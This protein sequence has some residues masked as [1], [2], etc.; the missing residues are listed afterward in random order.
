MT[1]RSYILLKRLRVVISIFMMILLTAYL[2]HSFNAGAPQSHN[3][4]AT[5]QFLPDLLKLLAMGIIIL[6]TIGLV[7]I[8]ILTLLF[9]RV[10]CSMI[11][12]LGI[13]QDIIS[14]FKRRVTPR[15]MHGYSSLPKL[16]KLR[17]SVLVLCVVAFSFG[18]I[19][20]VMLLEPFS[21]YSRIVNSILRPAY[22]FVMIFI[23]EVEYH[24]FDVTACI[25]TS[26][27]L[28]MLAAAVVKYGRIYCNT[29]CPVGSMLGFLSRFACFKIEIQSNC[30]NCGRCEKVCKAG[31][32]DYD[33]NEVDSSRC[34][35]CLN[36]AATCPFDAISIGHSA[37]EAELPSATETVDTSKR[38]FISIAGISV[39]ALPVMAAPVKLLVPLKYPVMPPGAMNMDRFN[40]KCTACHLCIGSCPSQII[41]PAL[42]AYGLKGFMQPYLNFTESV[43]DQD[44]NICTQ[45]CP[46]G[47][48][49]PLQVEDKNNLSIGLA[50]YIKNRCVVITNKT[51]C[52]SCAEEC[53]KGAIT[54]I[55]WQ[56]GLTIPKVDS[57]LCIGCGYCENACPSKPLKAIKV[58]GLA[59]QKII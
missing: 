42:T 3:W 59:E 58:K 15:R 24:S 50:D 39:L 37:P 7:T 45:V 49:L 55:N 34:I 25:F 48:L 52:G 56:D 16:V 1:Q 35:M 10:Y 21:F 36:C 31:C 11:C 5:T 43:C 14:W 47:A 6:P 12:P 44:C 26:I 33:N 41:R 17:T 4:I 27:T 46:T 2:L 22:A 32:I 29:L 20:P 54:M 57:T 40:G 8:I 9:G 53:P 38:E 13:L 18:F 23:E 51:P 28:I 19:F 30:R